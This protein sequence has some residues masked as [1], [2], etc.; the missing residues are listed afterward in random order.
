MKALQTISLITA[1]CTS[2]AVAQV[3]ADHERQNTRYSDQY[4]NS[5][6]QTHYVYADVV[7]VEPIKRYVSVSH[8]ER[9]CEQVEYDSRHERRHHHDSAGGTIAG[10]LIGGV[11]GSQIGSGSGKDVATI[12][13]VLIGSAIGHDNEVNQRRDHENDNYEVRTREQCQTRYERHEEERIEGYRVRYQFQG[14]TYTT[15][16]RFKPGN[17]IKL[18][19]TVR[20]V[21]D[22]YSSQTDSE[23][24]SDE[25]DR[26]RDYD[27]SD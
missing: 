25:D 24:Y 6:S 18:A 13:G 3:Y 2:V 10:G 16:T 22:E 20:P 5:S 8:P 12:A 9:V 21:A 1:L 26:Y 19:M 15:K 4:T 27:Y 23:K 17:K 14:K 11:L 7:D